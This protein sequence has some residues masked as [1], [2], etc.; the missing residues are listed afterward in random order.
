[1]KRAGMIGV[2]LLVF[3]TSLVQAQKNP[4][5]TFRYPSLNKIEVPDVKE[6][7]LPN[8]MKLLFLE[9]PAYPTI[10]LRAMI[11]TGSIW[12]PADQVGLASL[13]GE[14]MRTGGS[15][16]LSGDA[17]DVLLESLGATVETGIGQGSGYVS[18]SVLKE[19]IDKGLEILSELLMHPAFPQEKIDLAKMQHRSAIS[20]RNDDIGGIAYRE[21]EKVIYGSD[22][23]YAG[24]EE[25]ATIDAINRDDMVRFYK[26]YFHPN[27]VIFAA[28]GDFKKSD[29]KKKIEKAFAGWVRADV[30]VPAVP[31]V[32]YEYRS[33][34]NLIEKPDVNQSWIM[35]GHIGGL[36]N[37]PAY[38]A[39]ILMNQILSF[40]RLFKR[41][42][43][44]EGLAYH[45]SGSYGADFDHPGTFHSIC[46][47]KSQ[48]T[49]YAIGIMKEEI[50]RITREEV[51][52]EE[53]AKAKD[54][55]LNSFVFNFDSR[56][57]VVNRLMNC[58]YYQYPPDFIERLKTGVEKVTKA[59]VLKAA[60]SHVR[61][62]QL[63]VLVVGKSSDFDEPLSTLGNVNAIDIA[64]PA[65]EGKAPEATAESLRKGSQ[66]LA[67]AVKAAGGL[68]VFKTVN[69]A[70]NNSKMSISMP[71]GG[72]ME[73]TL[74]EMT[75]YPDKIRSEISMPFGQV[76]QVLNGDK[77]WVAS[78]QGVQDM[79]DSELKE[80][81]ASLFRDMIRLFQMSDGQ[82]LTVQ[83]IDDIDILG[84]KAQG[85]LVKDADGNSVKMYLDAETHLL[86]KREYQ[87][88][89]MMGMGTLEESLSDYRKIGNIMFPFHAEVK[90]NG[91]SYVTVDIQDVQLN[92][93]IDPALFQK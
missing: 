52:D 23:P 92:T 89:T 68:A 47:T 73:A 1:M 18:V 75:V 11:R 32:G 36:L 69:S 61:P 48:S 30:A 29:L 42:R 62:G 77:A 71:Q 64:I 70:T 25:Y 33:T 2:I 37:D 85:I 27:H 44:A 41:V 16:R 10:D 31:E 39:L 53:L 21:F 3:L 5:D 9:D 50:E 59:D 55:F 56:A 88:A 66:I 51:T 79:G 12:E 78:P 20:R 91:Q 14:V 67:N 28:W 90:A 84:K 38:P 57:E 26:Q 8:G 46:Q 13:V 63:Q 76:T 17:I 7:I 49:L 22:S 35:M 15:E 40:D 81:K 45:V 83:A 87:G 6:E 82:Q 65:V 43:S 93:A 24:Q 34:V 58:S 74:K 80:M 19:D 4:K 72:T 86:V 54:S 60:Q